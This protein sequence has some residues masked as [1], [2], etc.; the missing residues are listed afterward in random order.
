MLSSFCVPIKI[1]GRATLT[2]FKTSKVDPVT[3]FKR[4]QT[5]FRSSL[6]DDRKYFCCS[7]ASQLELA[8]MATAVKLTFFATWSLFYYHAIF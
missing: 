5:Y 1:L 7:Q 4:R 6:F 2:V 8:R 3:I